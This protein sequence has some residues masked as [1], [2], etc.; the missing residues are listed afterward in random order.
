MSNKPNHR[1]RGANSLGGKDIIQK[2]QEAVEIEAALAQDFTTNQMAL[3]EFEAATKDNP[4]DTIAAAALS[5]ETTLDTLQQL[6]QA[7]RA[8]KTRDDSQKL[9]ILSEKSAQSFEFL[10]AKFAS[11]TAKNTQRFNEA[12]QDLFSTGMHNLTAT[13]VAL[14]PT[15][16][17]ALN[18]P[19]ASPLTQTP[20]EMKLTIWVMQRLPGLVTENRLLNPDETLPGL[21]K[22]ADLRFTP[23]AFQTTQECLA[24]DKATNDMAQSIGRNKSQVLPEATLN[25]LNQT[26]ITE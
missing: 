4:D 23:E 2:S 1:E 22:D 6:Q 3:A 24:L 14:I 21:I 15:I 18:R 7:V 13:E 9:H 5:I 19:D 11:I 10:A 17:A 20:E 26:R 25:Q 8:D 16:A 12:K